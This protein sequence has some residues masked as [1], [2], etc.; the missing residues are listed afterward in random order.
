MSSHSK[1]FFCEKKGEVKGR[2]LDYDAKTVE[3]VPGQRCFS[4]PDR[5]LRFAVA[6][7]GNTQEKEEKDRGTRDRGGDTAEALGPSGENG[8]G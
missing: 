3:P 1:G 8:L 6:V 4:V 2:Q 7:D 5:G